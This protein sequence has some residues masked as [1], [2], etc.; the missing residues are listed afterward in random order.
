MAAPTPGTRAARIPAGI[1]LDEG[2]QTLISF[3]RL[4]TIGLWEK[5]VQPPGYDGGE[6]INIT[7]MH[8]I[9]F[10]NKAPAALIDVTNHSLKVAYDPAVYA[11]LLGLINYRDTVTVFFPDGSTLAY[12]GYMQK[13]EPD[14]LEEGKQPE[15]TVSIVVTNYDYVNHVYAA[16]AYTNVAGT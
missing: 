11:S 9:V 6:A 5:S 2:Y 14:A 4:P 13:F 12:Y 8:S 3:A 16:P 1:R 10:R 15:A 7:T